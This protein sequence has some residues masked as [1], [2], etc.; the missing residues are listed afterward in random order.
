MFFCFTQRL[1]TA[2][3]L[4]A[5]DAG[6]TDAFGVDFDDVESLNGH[7]SSVSRHGS[8]SAEASAGV[9]KM[10]A[11]IRALKSEL[12]STRMT[13]QELQGNL[14]Y[15]MSLLSDNRY[16]D[17]PTPTEIEERTKS[18]ASPSVVLIEML[19]GAVESWKAKVCNVI[20]LIIGADK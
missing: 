15:A 6:P 13:N 4:I 8:E 11:A 18:R 12:Q 7:V 19:T 2:K 17:T 10:K 9:A 5:E 1:H 16:F 14:E 3:A 20:S